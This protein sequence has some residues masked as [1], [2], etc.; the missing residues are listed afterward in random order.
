[1]IFVDTNYFLRFLLR[2]VDKEHQKAKKLFL[3]GAEGQIKLFTSSIVIFEIYWVLT[4]FYQR[5]KEKTIKI[6][7]KILAL[8]FIEIENRAILLD[9]LKI[10]QKTSL[11]FEDCYNLALI[12]KMGIKKIKT[13]DKKL[14]KEFQKTSLKS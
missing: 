14:Q 12:R 9:T 5:K 4:S 6:L 7:N 2:D 1:M 10:Y 13:F 8:G 3:K 11:E